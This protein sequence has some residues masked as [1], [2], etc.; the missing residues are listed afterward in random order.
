M[1]PS[2][3]SIL[4]HLRS[5]I[6]ILVTP[7]RRACIADFGLSSIANVMTLRFTHSTVYARG[8]TARYQSPELLRGEG[9]HYGSDV[10]AFACVC[11]EVR[12]TLVNLFPR[13]HNVV[14]QILTG[15]VPFHEFLNDMAVILQV[16]EGKRPSRP[17]S[18][19]GTSEVDSL[20]ELLQNCWD[21]NAEMRPNAP[22]IVERLVIP[23]IGAKTTSS[24]TDW[25][26]KSTSKFRSVLQT[27]SLLPTVTQIKRMIFGDG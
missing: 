16:V 7:S 4:F 20:W 17:M 10:Y 27:Q 5:Q 26:D 3:P 23:A 14:R 1:T 24:T 9:Q 12:Q 15:N 8:G 21:S 22:Q 11:Y 19:S 18:C 13:N 2:K 6:N 25:D